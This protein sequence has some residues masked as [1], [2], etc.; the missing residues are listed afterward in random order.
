MLDNGQETTT[1]YD[2][3]GRILS[4]V[5]ESDKTK[6]HVYEFSGVLD[7]IDYFDINGLPAG[8]DDFTYD[9]H[10]RRNGSTSVDGVVRALTYTDRGQI[11]TDTT[12]YGGQSYIVTYDYDSR[13]RN[14]EVLYPSG[15]KVNYTFTN[16]GELDLIKL[17][18]V[19][20][21]DRTYDAIG[22]LTNVD[23]AFVDEVRGYD[24]ANRLTSIDNTNVGTASY[25]YDANSNKLTESWS[26]VMSAWN[27]TT[28]NAGSFPDGYDEEDRFRNFIQSGQSK[29]VYI[30]RSDIGNITNHKV[31]STDTIRQY[32]NVHELNSVG[33][34]AQTFDDDGNLTD[35]YTG[36]ELAWNESGTLKQTIVSANDTAGIEGTNEYGYDADQKRVSKKITRNSTVVEN[37]VYIYAGPNCIAEYQSGMAPASPRSRICLRP[38]D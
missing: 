20:I 5:Q 14:D 23:R 7:R 38:G 21:E 13:G 16:R 19:Q 17:D 27:F 29:D 2:K 25:T 9:A 15:T 35:A 8:T 10:L 34:T 28:Q 31:N 18:D 4:V 24:N 1:T 32:S 11:A 37:T 33:G 3:A 22:R 6:T 30:D 12:T 26:G 36:I